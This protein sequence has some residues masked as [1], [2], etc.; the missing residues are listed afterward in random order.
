VLNH[1]REISSEVFDRPRHRAEPEN[2]AQAGA[3]GAQAEIGR[4]RQPDAKNRIALLVA[5][6]HR[7]ERGSSLRV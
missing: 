4:V 2:R 1:R 7:I 6:E 3:S 5:G